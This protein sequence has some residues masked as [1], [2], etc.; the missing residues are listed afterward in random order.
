MQFKIRVDYAEVEVY[1]DSYEEGEGAYVNSWDID[2]LKGMTFDTAEDLVKAIAK[3][4]WVFSEDLADYVYI[5]GRIDTDATV[6][7]NN[8]TPSDADFVA[9]RKGELMLYNAHLLCG[10]TMVPTGTE[11]EMTPE[12]AEAF[13]LSVY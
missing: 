12:E 13:G 2:A 11:H 9:W 5:D 7:V 10:V 6:D 3:N 8:E 1:E 4:S